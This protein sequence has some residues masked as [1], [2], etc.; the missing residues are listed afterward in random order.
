VSN[1]I[2]KNYFRKLAFYNTLYIM[3]RIIYS[4][5]LFISLFI[6]GNIY[7]QFFNATITPINFC[8]SASGVTGTAT[9]VNPPP[10]T[11]SYTWSF[12]SPTT[13]I[14]VPGQTLIPGGLPGTQIQFTLSGC[15]IYTLL[16]TAVNAGS[17]VVANVAVVAAITCSD[18]ASIITPSPNICQGTSSTLTALGAT[19]WTWSNGAN[20]SPLI[21]T[22]SVTTVYTATGTTAQGCTVQAAPVTI[23]VQPIGVNI[24][25]A[26]AQTVCPSTT[27]NLVAN[28]IGLPVTYSWT[29]A[30]T[31]LALG[32]TSLQTIITPTLAGVSV[33]SVLVTSGTCSA[34]ATTS[35]TVG[36]SL[37]VLP[38]S[39][40]SSVCPGTQV[41]TLS[42]SSIGTAYTWSVPVSPSAPNG[43]LSG[44]TITRTISAPYTFTVRAT[45]TAPAC[46]GSTVITVGIS[47]FTPTLVSSSP[48]VCPGETFTLTSTGGAA[49]SYTFGFL[50]LNPLNI[51]GAGVTSTIAVTQSSVTVWGVGAT[52]TAGCTNSLNPTTVTVGITPNVVINA[53]ASSPSVCATTPVTLTANG[54]ASYTWVS[55]SGATLT[56]VGP[57]VIVVNPAVATTYS[58]F[59]TNAAGF[60]G[61][62]TTVTVGMTAGGTLNFTASANANVVCAG[63]QPTLTA[64]GLGS[65]TYNWTPTISL[66][67]TSGSVVIASPSVNTVY[68][69]LA[70]NGGGCT[71]TQTVGITI[72]PTPTL[73]PINAS[74]SAICAGFTS[75][76]TAS[77]IGASSYTWTGSTILN[78]INQPSIS[79]SPGTYT[80]IAGSAVANCPSSPVSITITLAPPLNITTSQ[81]SGTTC[82]TENR[83]IKRSAPVNLVA[84]GGGVYTWFP[85][86]PAYM[87]FSVGPTTTEASG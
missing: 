70:T 74:A 21:V 33:Y 13:S 1:F 61:N 14:T 23:T 38:S 83:P 43:T 73:F 64:V 76:L 45:S 40:S 39:S 42:A 56:P 35:I 80:V 72:S 59:G 9:A 32:T 44:S 22:P 78:P 18:A 2:Y 36:G 27:V 26:G 6:S 51:V 47:T 60:C 68:T 31:S 49:N 55:S 25:P 65:F 67:P 12:V 86:N 24:T 87:T 30:T 34:S 29:N 79:V 5:F 20:G 75:T 58:V 46:S 69:V 62:F 4:C 71:G 53:F 10:G 82:I 85:Y 57:S 3:K 54:A 41:F 11:A 19:T 66:S 48:S 28:A 50:P 17:G 16:C 15:G 77:G 7:A 8:Y 63:V 52:S 84:S 37:S 81:S